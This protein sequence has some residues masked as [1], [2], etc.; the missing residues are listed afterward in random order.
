MKREKLVKDILDSTIHRLEADLDRYVEQKCALGTPMSRRTAI[1]LLDRSVFSPER[2][3][4]RR[5][6]CEQR[7][8]DPS[9]LED[10]WR[11]TIKRL[12]RKA[13]N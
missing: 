6:E 2:I 7:G 8:V 1:D 5:R 11:E 4:A 12:R 3:K 13:D 9:V 10:T